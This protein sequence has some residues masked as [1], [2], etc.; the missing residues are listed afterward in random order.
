MPIFRD[1]LTALRLA[2]KANVAGMA[3][4]VL[5]NF[6]RAEIM[7]EDAV[8]ASLKSGAL[9]AYACDFPSA[10]LTG[11]PKVKGKFVKLTRTASG[12]WDCTISGGLEDKYLPTGCL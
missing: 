1:F 8:I 4:G 9:Q 10:K 3:A 11:N 2:L 7:D 12:S 6:A 5:L